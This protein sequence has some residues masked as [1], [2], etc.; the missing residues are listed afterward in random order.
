M[1]RGYVPAAGE[2]VPELASW[3]LLVRLGA[4]LEVTR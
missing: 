4:D 1:C 2:P 3:E